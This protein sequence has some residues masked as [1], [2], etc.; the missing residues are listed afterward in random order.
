MNG[1][2]SI[3]TG[4]HKKWFLVI[5]FS[6]CTETRLIFAFGVR[7]CQTVQRIL[8]RLNTD[9]EGNTVHKQI[10][11]VKFDYPTKNDFSC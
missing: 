1:V 2:C 4:L 10:E 8:V 11:N 6:V 3:E 5:F 9:E 7:A